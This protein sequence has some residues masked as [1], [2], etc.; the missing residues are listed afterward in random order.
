M[1][2]KN[3]SSLDF[4]GASH[5]VAPPPQKEDVFRAIDSPSG[6]AARVTNRTEPF[7]NRV[8][9][10]F[11]RDFNLLAAQ[12]GVKKV[13]LL[14]QIFEYFVSSGAQAQGGK[15]PQPEQEPPLREKQAGRIKPILLWGS[16]ITSP[17]LEEL[18][19]H[20]GLTPSELLE[21][22]I[23]ERIQGFEEQGVVFNFRRK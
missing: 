15:K 7:S 6:H 23:A 19:I 18:A 12:H 11:K 5:S 3:K 8:T 22:M 2:E 9:P 14:E 13:E 1:S 10:Q 21:D 4:S 17:A 20:Q 16:A